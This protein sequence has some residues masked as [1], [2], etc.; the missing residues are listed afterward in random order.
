[1][2]T[3][4]VPNEE[5]CQRTFT[6][7]ETGPQD[8]LMTTASKHSNAGFRIVPSDI[9]NDGIPYVDHWKYGRSGHGGNCLT[10]CANGD[11]VSFYSN[12]SGEI[13]RGHGVAGWSEYRR[14]R[15]GGETWSGPT[16]LDYS[17]RAWEDDDVYSA[18][19][20]AV[21]TAPNGTLIAFVCRFASA[22]WI[23]KL[24][25]VYLLS[26]DHGETWSEPRP[27][28]PELTV[29]DVSLTFDAVFTHDDKVFAVFMGG[30]ANYCDGPHS[31]FVSADNGETFQRRSILPFDLTD[32]YVT[33]G[34]LDSGDIIVYSYPYRADEDID[35]YNIPYVTSADEGRTWSEVK[36]TH[37]ARAIRNPQ[38]SR[39]IGSLY[40]LHGRSGS[41]SRDPK[42]LALYSS[43]DGIHWDEGR[44][45]HHR[46]PG[47]GGGDAYSANEVIGKYDPSVPNRLLI[48]SSI[49]YEPDSLKVNER[50]WWVEGIDGA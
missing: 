14:S 1:M 9:P 28:A 45:L 3:L 4:G 6:D 38:L 44:I 22:G 40:F 31:F 7:A 39:K 16:V 27:L 36:T 42:H 11:I 29:E 13:H 12:V 25:P 15:D 17:K 32:Y 2:S 41:H 20:F 26:R 18:L 30:S 5:A 43:L 23:K 10:E 50:H 48:Q 47:E 24:P 49:S 46:G 19:V 8:K 33:A 37:F 35:E 34:V 21:T